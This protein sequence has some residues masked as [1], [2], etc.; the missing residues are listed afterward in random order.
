VT[1]YP[2][3]LDNIS[4]VIKGVAQPDLFA[5]AATDQ[6]GRHTLKPLDGRGAAIAVAV[7]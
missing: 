3:F 6:G 5:D 1:I 4:V 2:N 7:R